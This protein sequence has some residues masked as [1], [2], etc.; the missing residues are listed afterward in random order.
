MPR[1]VLSVHGTA[2]CRRSLLLAAGSTLLLA[3]CGSGSGLDPLT[4]QPGGG[5]AVSGDTIGTG[6]VRVGLILPLSAAG[7]VGQA[8][9]A[10]RNAA[11]LA[12]AEFQEPDLTLLVKDD[13][14]DPG[15]A[16]EAARR[17]IAEGAELIIGPLL[18]PTVASAGQVAK[19][20]NRPVIAFSS[21]TSVAQPGVY[22]LSF[23]PQSDVARIVAYAA[24]RG[25]RSFAALLPDSPF[26]NVI[27]AEFQQQVARAGGRVTS[28][29]RYQTGRAADSARR[30]AG[31]LAGSDALLATDLTDQMA[32][33][34]AA[35]G[36]AGI[37]GPR[38]QLLGTGTW[39]DRAVLAQPALQGGWFAAPDASGYNAFAGRYRNRFKAD[40]T[41]FATLA[42]DAVALAAALV[43]TQGANRF[44]PQTLTSG[45]GF[46][47][48]DGVFRFRED[49]TNERAL[50]VL[51]VGNRSATVVSA[52]PRSFGAA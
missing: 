29:E 44:R 38:V 34:A 24:G 40:P 8:A 5:P 4:S 12:M 2:P 30:L 6:Q 3:G 37:G 13:R 22:L 46:A 39:N 11:D 27:E 7:G 47:G 48:Q 9:A 32:S 23:T 52:A 21:D 49:G 28:V 25:K 26:G 17:A 20:A 36:S 15:A 18:A 16:A 33:L 51:Q 35:L 43:R 41:R 14:G 42:Y 19:A 10:M 1:S 50:A 45:S 31:N